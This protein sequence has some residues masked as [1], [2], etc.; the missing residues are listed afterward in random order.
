MTLCF[1]GRRGLVH[2]QMKPAGSPDGGL[3]SDFILA[4]AMDRRITSTI[5]W[6]RRFAV[7]SGIS[8]Q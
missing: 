1:F 5:S 2:S 6:Q 3:R 8:T 7:F 4:A